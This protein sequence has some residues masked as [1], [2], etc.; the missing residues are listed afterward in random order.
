MERE[1]APFSRYVR[2]GFLCIAEKNRTPS[3]KEK[4]YTVEWLQIFLSVFTNVNL[5]SY[6]IKTRWSRIFLFFFPN[7][8]S[9]KVE[10]FHNTTR[11]FANISDIN[12]MKFTVISITINCN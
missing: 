9:R 8:L 4:K 12:I 3:A 7:I 5:Y 10:K 1:R 11:S 2:V 6:S